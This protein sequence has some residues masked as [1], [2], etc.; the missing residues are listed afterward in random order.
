MKGKRPL[1]VM[2]AGPYGSGTKTP[3]EKKANLAKLNQTALAVFRKGYIPVVGVNNALPLIVVAGEDGSDSIM[4]RLSVALTERCDCCLRVG[5]L[6]KGA[7]REV[8]SFKT[9]SKPVYYA[10]DQ[11]P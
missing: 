1:W 10:I 9:E 5:G 4:M 6:S 7:D 3:E 8:E 11:L 2:I